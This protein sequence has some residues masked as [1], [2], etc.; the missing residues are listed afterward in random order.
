MNKRQW[1]LMYLALSYTSSNLDDLIEGF[2]YDDE[3]IPVESSAGTI[4]RPTA[5][6]VNELLSMARKNC[7]DMPQLIERI[8]QQGGLTCCQ[9]YQGPLCVAKGQSRKGTKH[10]IKNAYRN[11]NNEKVC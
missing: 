10:A 3:D 4:E 6:E 2:G 11:Y 8:T 5:K 7:K 1:Q 9:L